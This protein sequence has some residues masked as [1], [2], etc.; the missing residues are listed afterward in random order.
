MR[1]IKQPQIL[2][3]LG[4]FTLLHLFTYILIGFVFLIFQDT[5]QNPGE[6]HWTIMNTFRPLGMMAVVGQIIR[7]ATLHLSFIP[8]TVLFKNPKAG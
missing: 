6:L 3:Y 2:S 7:V 8:F 5:L 1:E 4:R